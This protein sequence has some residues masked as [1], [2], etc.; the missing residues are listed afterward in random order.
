MRSQTGFRIPLI[1]KLNATTQYNVDWDNTPTGGR[2]STD[3]I[4]LLT[5]GYAW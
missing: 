4:L 3:K 2:G 1:D 5:V